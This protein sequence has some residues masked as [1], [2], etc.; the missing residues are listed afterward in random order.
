MKKTATTRL[1]NIA[2]GMET[3]DDYSVALERM[4]KEFE[5]PQFWRLFSTAIGVSIYGQPNDVFQYS[6]WRVF[7]T[8]V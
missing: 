2:P 5:F 6:F 7:P 1:N 8:G 4:A 3:Y